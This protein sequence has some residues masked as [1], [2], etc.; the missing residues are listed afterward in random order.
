MFNHLLTDFNRY[1][2][3]S[4]TYTNKQTNKIPEKTEKSLMTDLK[5]LTK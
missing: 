5:Y 4:Q 1:T 3:K 2:D